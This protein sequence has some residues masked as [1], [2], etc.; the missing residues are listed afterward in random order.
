MDKSSVK[1]KLQIN[2]VTEE[3]TPIAK[4]SN[5]KY[6]SRDNRCVAI[7]ASNLAAYFAAS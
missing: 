6:D 4:E 3:P 7:I 1:E 5:N 2:T